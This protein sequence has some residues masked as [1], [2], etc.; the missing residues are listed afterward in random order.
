ML[1]IL[2]KMKSF[3]QNMK[4]GRNNSNEYYDDEDDASSGPL[5]VR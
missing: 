4:S 2:K 3:M 1:V 5:N